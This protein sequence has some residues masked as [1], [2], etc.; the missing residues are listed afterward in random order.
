[1]AISQYGSVGQG[2]TNDSDV[3]ADQDGRN[4]N[5]RQHR[6]SEQTPLLHTSYE[7][8]DSDCRS[9]SRYKYCVG[10]YEVLILI[11]NVN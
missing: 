4:P 11:F 10:K 7:S 8:I 1:M 6:D 3:E 5:N 2:V 9:S